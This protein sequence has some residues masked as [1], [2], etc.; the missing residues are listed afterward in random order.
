MVKIVTDVIRA[1]L[2]ACEIPL[3]GLTIYKVKDTIVELYPIK[4]SEIIM[5]K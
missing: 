4:N 1:E 2:L 3:L 5:N